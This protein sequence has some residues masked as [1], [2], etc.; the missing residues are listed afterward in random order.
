MWNGQ[1]YR[2]EGGPVVHHNLLLGVR[3][4][5]AVV[6][7]HRLRMALAVTVRPSLGSATEKVFTT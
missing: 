7:S 3:L 1:Q 6:V 4:V 2:G 5:V